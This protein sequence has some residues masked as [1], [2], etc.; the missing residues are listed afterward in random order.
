MISAKSQPNQTFSIRTLLLYYGIF[1]D[2]SLFLY[3][4]HALSHSAIYLFTYLNEYSLHNVMLALSIIKTSENIQI[5]FAIKNI[6]IIINII[7]SNIII[8]SFA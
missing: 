3:I 6:V 1:I 8:L 4:H 5:C 2:H 7:N